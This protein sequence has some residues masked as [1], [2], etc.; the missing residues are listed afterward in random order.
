MNISIS[1]LKLNWI[2]K[3]N[4]I[5]WFSPDIGQWVIN[6]L[7]YIKVIILICDSNRKYGVATDNGHTHYI[8]VVIPLMDPRNLFLGPNQVSQSKVETE[9]WM[10]DLEVPSGSQYSMKLDRLPF[11]V[12]HW[13]MQDASW[14][15]WLQPKKLCSATPSVESSD[16]CH[17]NKS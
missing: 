2:G 17:R 16:I 1:R 6:P 9:A 14:L 7:T 5:F 10:A 8:V 3:N 4:S 15:I 11:G 13:G 12:V